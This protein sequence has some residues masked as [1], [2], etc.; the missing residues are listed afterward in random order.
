MATLVNTF[1]E[2][3]EKE[4][5]GPAK[6]EKKDRIG[7]YTLKYTVYVDKNRHNIQGYLKVVQPERQKEV[8]VEEVGE[9]QGQGQQGQGQ[10]EVEQVGEVEEVRE[11]KTLKD[12]KMRQIN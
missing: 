3:N 4:K 2:K 10:E 1:L 5:T 12:S 8:V 9:Q 11:V 7:V 6:L